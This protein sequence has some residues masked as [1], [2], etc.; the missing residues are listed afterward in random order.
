MRQNCRQKTKLDIT[1]VDVQISRCRD[2]TRER[3]YGAFSVVRVFN[4]CL[5][6]LGGRGSWVTI[7]GDGVSL[8]RRVLG[9]GGTGL[10]RDAI[11][12]DYDS[13]VELGLQGRPDGEGFYAC[14]LQLARSTAWERAKAHWAHPS[15]A[16][17][18]PY[19][20][21]LLSVVLGLL[22]LILG[23]ISLVR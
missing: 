5:D 19:R 21:A 3:D 9:S 6:S 22:G 13:R 23:I 1:E 4:G 18:V 12:L 10:T 14:N 16:Y 8:Y 17:R 15:L 7:V 2:F 11:E 20:L